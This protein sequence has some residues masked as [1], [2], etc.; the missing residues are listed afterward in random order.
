MSASPTALVNA[1]RDHGISELEFVVYPAARHETLNE[2]NREEVTED[3]LNWLLR[4]I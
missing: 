2:T 4:R 3:L 1:Y